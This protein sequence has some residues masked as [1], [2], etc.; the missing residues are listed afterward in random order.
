M[1][2]LF[3]YTDSYY[4]QILW[5]I[6]SLKITDK[7]FFADKFLNLGLNLPFELQCGNITIL[8]TDQCNSTRYYNGS[9][10]ETGAI[11]AGNDDP[12]IGYDYPFLQSPKIDAC[13]VSKLNYF[14]KQLIRYNT[15]FYKS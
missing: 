9:I 3:Q 4:I 14:N 8:P 1:V 10:P 5:F 11:C 12:A 13:K 7:Y 15:A 2:I 6:S